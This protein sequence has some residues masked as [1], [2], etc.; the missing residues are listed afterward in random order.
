MA[1]QTET[2][3]QATTDE[4]KKADAWMNLRSIKNK[5][6]QEFPLQGIKT[7]GTA[8]N[9]DAGGLSE[10]LIE[11]AKANDGKITVTLVAEIQVVAETKDA[12]SYGEF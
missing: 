10:A 7:Y 8:L 3:K 12:L 11:Q 2:Q 9:V 1:F 5:S 6:G 4:K